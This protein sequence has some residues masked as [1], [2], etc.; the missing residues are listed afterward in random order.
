MKQGWGTGGVSKDLGRHSILLPDDS[1]RG[2]RR[3]SN[4][5]GLRRSETYL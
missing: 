1:S 4:D 3:I 5:Q 2:V